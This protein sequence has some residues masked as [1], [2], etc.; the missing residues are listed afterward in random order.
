MGIIG[1]NPEKGWGSAVH[2]PAVHAIPAL[3]L[4]AVATTRIETAKRSAELFGAPNHFADPC[5]LVHDDEVD[6]V[7][8]AVRAPDHYRLAMLALDA[9]KH[10]YCEWPLATTVEQAAEMRQLAEQRGV[11]A[12]VG[13]QSRGAPA[14]RFVR[15]LV[16]EGYA[17]RLV[18]VRMRCSLPGGGRRRSRE[19]LYVIDKENGASTIRIQGGHAIDALRFCVGDFQQLCGTVVNHFEEIEVIETAA[20]VPKSAPDQVVAAG[21][22]VGGVPVSIAV[23]GGVVAGHGVELEI[24]GEQGALRVLGTGRLN[25]QMSPLSVWGAQSPESDLDEIPIPSGYDPMVI[26]ADATAKAP[27]PGVDVPRATLVNV[28]NLYRDMADAITAGTPAT[29]DF[30]VGLSLHRLIQALED[31]SRAFAEKD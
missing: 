14:L 18:S 25:F 17:G 6:L 28:A 31:S 20:R 21:R 11:K 2:I 27:Y 26:P 16:N 12:V 8:I 30:G 23:S 4:N 10:V 29:P 19:G 15:D 13:L 24:L 1:A 22:L 5:A 3:K 9:G 7:S